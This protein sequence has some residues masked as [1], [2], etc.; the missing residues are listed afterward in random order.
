MFIKLLLNEGHSGAVGNSRPEHTHS[1]GI[2]R[3]EGERAGVGGGGEEEEKGFSPP[4]VA[5]ESAFKVR[6][7]AHSVST[8][9]APIIRSTKG[10]YLPSQERLEPRA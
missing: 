8:S 6:T 5:E 3:R 7:H 4:L 10:K 9:K 1:P 2:V